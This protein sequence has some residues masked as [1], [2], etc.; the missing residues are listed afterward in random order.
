M[1]TVH[2][3]DEAVRKLLQA[4]QENWLRNSSEDRTAHLL[5]SESLIPRMIQA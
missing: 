3:Q 1:G 5:R 2:I 4:K